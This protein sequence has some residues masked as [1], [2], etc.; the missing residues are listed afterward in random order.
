MKKIYR[1]LF[2]IALSLSLGFLIG[3][4]TY[5]IAIDIEQGS[6]GIYAFR[7]MPDG[8]LVLAN[9][10]CYPDNDECLVL[11]KL[12]LDGELLWQKRYRNSLGRIKPGS[13]TGNQGIYIH[14]DNT[15]YFSGILRTLNSDQ[16]GFLMRTNQLGDSLWMKKYGGIHYDRQRSI[17]SLNDSTILIL[18][19]LGEGSDLDGS[20]ARLLAVDLEGNF[21]WEHFYG[22]QYPR[23]MVHDIMKL[24]DETLILT[25]LAC[26]DSDD[27]H[28]TE[29]NSLRI[30]KLQTDGE[31]IWDKSIWTITSLSVRSTVLSLDDGNFAISFY[32]NNNEGGYFTPPVLLWVDSLG[33]LMHHHEFPVDRLSWI[34]DLIQNDEGN[35]ICV[36]TVDIIPEG[37]IE[38]AAW[39]CAFNLEGELLWNRYVK[40]GRSPYTSSE[41]ATGLEMS[42]GSLILGGGI[43]DSIQGRYDLW[44]LKLDSDGCFDPECG[45]YQIITAAKE[46]PLLGNHFKIFPNPATNKRELIIQN[47]ETNPGYMYSVIDLLGHLVYAG[48]LSSATEQKM[49]TQEF[50]RGLYFVQFWN[51]NGQLMQVEKLIIE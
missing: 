27:C 46:V 34:S 23:S 15:F 19:N 6:E 51:E 36:G 38:R 45:E 50:Q 22:D 41:L 40:D 47:P 20:T 3:Q 21:L 9:S 5:S 43:R 18:N 42:D 26:E 11:A 8:F 24:E 4:D 10:I 31:V 39:V 17:L 44:L 2:T 1:Y 7:S 32:R 16:D 33:N 30:A 37:L 48:K 49:L 29:T 13:S 35:I 12:G 28:Y 25:Y 14:D